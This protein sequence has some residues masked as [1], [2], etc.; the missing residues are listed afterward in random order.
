MRTPHLPI[1]GVIVTSCGFENVMP[2][3]KLSGI[4]PV[5][6]YFEIGHGRREFFDQFLRGIGAA[7]GMTGYSASLM[8]SQKPK[9]DGYFRQARVWYENGRDDTQTMPFGDFIWA[10]MDSERAW[11]R[12]Q[13]A[14]IMEQVY[15]HEYIESSF[16]LN[17]GLMR[18][19]G[20]KEHK[21]EN[22]GQPC[23]GLIAYT[24]WRIWSYPHLTCA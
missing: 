3:P 15:G 22:Y 5:I 21:Y 4:D 13:G 12:E 10:F 8:A 11:L 17:F 16:W 14:N 20:L 18:Q 24:E 23:T 9:D 2:L 6:E 7:A 1:D 19:S